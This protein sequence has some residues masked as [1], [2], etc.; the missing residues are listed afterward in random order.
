MRRVPVTWPRATE[1]CA[2]A[3]LAAVF[4]WAGVPKLLE[5]TEFAEAIGNYRIVPDAW[6]GALAVFLPPLELIVAGALTLGVGKRGAA[7]IA[8]GM[9]IVFAVAIGQTVVRGIDIDCGC[10]GT[11]QESEASWWGV[12]RN[13]ALTS[14]ALAVMAL[15]GPRPVPGNKS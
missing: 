14:C 12:V 11:A 6:A 7:L 1:I 3:V 9:L 2:R 5:P 8:A 4:V 10:F 13:V 15:G